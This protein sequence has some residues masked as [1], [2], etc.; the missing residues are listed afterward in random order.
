MLRQ[1]GKKLFVATNSL[2]DYTHVVMNWVLEGKKGGERD[3]AWLQYFDA[4]RGVVV[5][6]VHGRMGVCVW[7]GGRASGRGEARHG[8]STLAW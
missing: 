2:W 3:E 7:G 1:S 6:V 4:V 8:C 5:F